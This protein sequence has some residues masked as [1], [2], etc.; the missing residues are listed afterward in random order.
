M[1]IHGKEIP[2]RGSNKK[3]FELDNLDNLYQELQK[4]SIDDLSRELNVPYNSINWRVTQNFPKEWKNNIVR[5]R[6]RQVS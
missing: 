6:R 3:Y 2:K 4:K 5:K 1:I